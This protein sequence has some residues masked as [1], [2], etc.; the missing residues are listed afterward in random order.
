MRNK[1]IYSV[2]LV[3][4]IS[5]SNFRP[6]VFT[7]AYINPQT[8]TVVTYE[9]INWSYALF[10]QYGSG[11][12]YGLRM[13][14]DAYNV[15]QTN[16][17]LRYQQDAAVSF[18]FNEWDIITATYVEA[19]ELSPTWR[20]RFNTIFFDRSFD[21]TNKKP[22]FYP[23]IRFDKNPILNSVNLELII[24][25]K[26]SYNVNIGSVY[27]GFYPVPVNIDKIES[28][29]SFFNKDN[30]LLQTILLDT[31]TVVSG[32]L[33]SDLY[34]LSTVITNV[35]RFDFKVQM[36][37]TPPYTANFS[38]YYFFEFNIFTQNQE[39]EI[40]DDTSGDRFGF[41]FV[42]VEWWDIL[43][44]LQNFIWWIVN[45]SPVAPVFEFI[46]E[47]VITWISGLIDLIT[48]VFNL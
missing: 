37:D 44:H 22:T 47:Y 5:C 10:N 46:D 9:N 42:A 7:E 24:K 13:N 35:N 43:G 30:Q 2:A 4:L 38:N 11:L 25:S 40:P 12:S 17:A 45:K 16:F 32:V 29:I 28:W 1:I 39:I 33:Q 27:N 36:I 14:F 3:S 15:N 23:H 41:E 18:L 19:T 20:Q 8:T 31:E 34:N 48:G 26:I 21:R 6:Y